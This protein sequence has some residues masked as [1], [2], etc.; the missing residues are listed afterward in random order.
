MCPYFSH[1][2][3]VESNGVRSSDCLKYGH[4]SEERLEAIVPGKSCNNEIKNFCKHKRFE[5]WRK[6]Y[7]SKS[8]KLQFLLSTTNLNNHN[9]IQ[10]N[11]N[12]FWPQLALLSRFYKLESCCWGKFTQIALD[13]IAIVHT[14][15]FGAKF[16]MFYFEKLNFSK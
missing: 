11:F 4:I 1:W 16:Q 15:I 2:H 10:C 12:G 9:A 14:N 13:H 5:I 7:L 3:C 8:I 6:K